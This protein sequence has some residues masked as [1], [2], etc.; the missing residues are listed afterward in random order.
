MRNLNDDFRELIVE[1]LAE[2]ALLDLCLQ[3]LVC[4]ADEGSTGISCRPPMRSITRS[5]RNRSA[6]PAAPSADRRSRR[7]TAIRRSPSI[8][9]SVCF[10]AR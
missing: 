8:L 4:R 5:C 3:A 1:I 6:S 7:G 2:L 10:A 9:P